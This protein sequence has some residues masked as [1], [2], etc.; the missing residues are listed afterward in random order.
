[1]KSRG[2]HMIPGYMHKPDADDINVIRHRVRVLEE[3]LR[4][5]TGKYLGPKRIV[6]LLSDKVEKNKV[7][8]H[9]E[10]RKRVKRACIG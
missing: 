3:M 1:M 2:Y 9:I 8:R 10:Y 4:I 7:R 6:G 5:E